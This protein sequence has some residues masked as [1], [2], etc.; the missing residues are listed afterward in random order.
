MRL[1]GWI[2]GPDFQRS[3]NDRQWV[4]IN[5]RMVKDKLIN[6]ALKQAYD[7]L[8]YP[9]RFPACLLYFTINSAEVDV[10][11]HPT[12]HEVRFQQPRLVHDFFTSQLT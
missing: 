2:S 7:G 1:D 4:Y 3:Q 9:G 12:K 11:V 8:F 5:Q 10:N 6:H